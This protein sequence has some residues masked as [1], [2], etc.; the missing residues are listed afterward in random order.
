MD[1]NVL[2]ESGSESVLKNEPPTI[3]PT[4]SDLEIKP[5]LCGEKLASIYSTKRT[6]TRP[7]MPQE[8]CIMVCSQKNCTEP[9][10]KLQS[11]A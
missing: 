4:K 11:T 7:H 1:T 3:H 9:H 5:A 10:E 6:N 8:H 2:E